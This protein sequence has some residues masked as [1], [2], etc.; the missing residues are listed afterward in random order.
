MEL[1]KIIE[2]I[3]LCTI[4]SLPVTL[5]AQY[6][7]IDYKFS[8]FADTYHA[9][10][11]Q[12]PYDFMSSRTRLRTELE[13]NRENSYLFTSINSQYN[14]LLPEQTGIELREAF[15][16][17]S[18]SNWDFKAGRQIVIW[19]VSDGMSV[20][21]IVSPMDYNEFLARDYDD[22]RIPVNAVKL[23]YFNSTLSAE[24]I[25]IP[26]SAYF[27]IPTAPNNPWSMLPQRKNLT[28]Q[29]DIE[30]HPKTSLKNSEY[31]GR[32]SFFL[33]GIDFSLATL[34][35]WNKMPIMQYI[36]SANRDTIFAK[37]IFER[38]DM[39]GADFSM[40]LGKFVIRGEVAEYFGNLQQTNDLQKLRRNTTKMLL[41]LDWYPGN[42]WTI[43]AQYSHQYIPD[44][45]D[46]I[47]SPENMSISTFGI[48]KLLMENT[49]K[50]STFIYSDLNNNGFF[51]R[52]SIDYSLSDQIHLLLGYD[53]FHGDE[54]M[55]GFYKDNSEVWLKA[56]YSF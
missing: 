36:P 14:S 26:T 13:V 35:T 45:V 21:D 12:S 53:W 7:E 24:A 16:Q 39:L 11:S 22:I 51:N 47:T 50:L 29:T 41:G 56:K 42:D 52:S 31:G 44:Y 10:R 2:R 15:F 8:G 9:V 4:L 20:T 49:L 28:Y 40:P 1:S 23:K 43:T 25:F 19:G 5:V 38:M 3:V 33:S 17:Y 30:N 34:H 32:L 6:E 46:A 55:F 27:I 54:G 18:T 37:G 48:T